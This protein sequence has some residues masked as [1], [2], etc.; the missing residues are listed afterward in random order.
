MK[1]RVISI[2]IAAVMLV[3]A[4]PM[5]GLLSGCRNTGGSGFPDP[6]PIVFTGG[7]YS[8]KSP[9]L[10][11]ELSSVKITADGVSSGVIP[12]D[13]AFIVETSG[14]TDVETLANYLTMT[15]AIATSVTRLSS[16]KFRIVPSSGKLVPG[17][18]YR[19]TLGDPENPAASYAFQTQNDMVVTSMFPGDKTLNVPVDT[20]IEVTFSEAVVSEP[21]MKYF[22]VSPEVKGE[23]SVYPNGRTVLFRP[24][25]KLEYNTVYTVTVNSGIKGISG[26]TLESGKTATFRTCTKAYESALGSD[27]REF[28]RILTTSNDGWDNI[29]SPRSDA[30]MRFTVYT[31][32]TETPNVTCDLYSFG[33]AKEAADTIIAFETRAGDDTG[34]GPDLSGLTKV[35][36]F[37]PQTEKDRYTTN[38]FLDLGTGLARG[39]YVAKITAS[40]S[41]GFGKT[42]KDTKSVIIQVSN[43]RPYTVSSNGK[44]IIWINSIANAEGPVEGAD[45]TVSLLSRNEGWNAE[46]VGK[47]QKVKTDASGIAEFDSSEAYSAVIIAEK[48]SDGIVV[49]AAVRPEDTYD[50]YLSYVYTDREVYFSDD[51]INFSGYITP[52]FG[53]TVPDHLYLETGLSTLKTRVE[54]DKNG[55][56]RGSFTYS[57][58]SQG[59]YQLKFSDES[60]R[61][62]TSGTFRITEE[63]KPQYTASISFDKLF[64]RRGE[65][66]T[67]TLTAS[68][69]DGTPAEGLEFYCMLS[70]FGDAHQTVRTDEKGEAKIVYKSRNLTDREVRGT[71]PVTLYFA[72]ELTNF[73][74]QYLYVQDS[75]PYFHSD[76]CVA[77]R[78]D[79]TNAVVTLNRRDTS[80]LKTP[81]NMLWRVFPENTVGEPLSAAN[82]LSYTL[83]KNVIVR[84]EKTRYDSYTKKNVKYYTC[85]VRKSKVASDVKSFVNGVA[86]FPLL[87]VSGF[88][89][90]YTYEVSFYDDTSN[91]TYTYTLNGTAGKTGTG[92]SGS[93]QSLTAEILFNDETYSVSDTVEAE[94]WTAPEKRKALF[95]IR[96]NGI[97]GVEYG[98]KVRFSFTDS[99]IAD[100]YLYAVVFDS[101][102]GEYLIPG[103]E[104][105][106]D[107]ANATLKPVITPS[108]DTYKPGD[109]AIVKIRVPGAGGGVAVVSIVDEACFALGDQEIEPL[110]IFSKQRSSAATFLMNARFKPAFTNSDVDYG[111]LSYSNG[112]KSSK[113]DNSLSLSE[114]RPGAAPESGELSDGGIGSSDWYIRKYFAD[115]PVYDVVELDSDGCGTLVFTVPD[116]ITSWRISTYALCGTGSENGKLKTGASVSDVICTLPFFVNVGICEQYIVGDTISLS[117]R[118]YGSEATG[119]VNYTAVLT[120]ALGNEKGRT[121]GSADSKERCWLKFELSE[122][123]QYHV[124]VYA[125][126]GENKDAATT[127]F[128]LVTSAVAADVGR[129]LAV[130]ELKTITPVYYPVKVVFANRT[131]SYAFYERI[132]SLLSNDRGSGRT[133]EYAGLYAAAAAR[134]ALYGIKAD[135]EQERLMRLM[136]DNFSASDGQFRVFPYSEP[137][138]ELTALILTLGLPFDTQTLNYI[139]SACSTSVNSTDQESPEKLISNVVSLAALGEPVLDTLYVIA[140]KAGNYSPEAKLLLALGF[141]VCGDYPAAHDVY[142]LVKSEIGV[143]DSEYGSLKFEAGDFDTT[144]QLSCLAL[145]S[146]ARID[147]EDAAKLALWLSENRT[148][149]VSDRIALAAYIKHFLPQEAADALEFTYTIGESSETVKIEPGCSF[150]LTLSKQELDSLKTSLPGDTKVGVYYR[151]TMEEAL[152]DGQKSDGRVSITKAMTNDSHGNCLV[153]LRISGRST[154]VNEYFELYDLIPSGARFLSI[155][156]SSSSRYE[157]GTVAAYA[158]IY[159]SSGQNMTG[160]VSLHNR[161][162]ENENNWFRQDCPEYGFEIS[163]SYVIRG[164]VEGTFTAESAYIR[165][166]RT[167]AFSLTDRIRVT[168]NEKDKWKFE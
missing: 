52:S 51:T 131:P 142:A 88:E 161:I 24:S 115:N 84:T 56:F 10:P 58:C 76:Y 33:S 90:Y 109:K 82:A 5:G 120:D 160:G 25:S 6:E 167:G 137:D 73:E 118:S 50:Y 128:T 126:C 77:T 155:D 116:N 57:R 7:D 94:I 113:G 22:T 139:A 110:S 141:A 12:V 36:T 164:A 32:I 134:E 135:Q 122:P 69:F 163:V 133:D 31:S 26:R 104:I 79:K 13:G 67:V 61:I 29:F 19:L 150:T 153:T 2:I 91:N 165:N 3:S 78:Q 43:F 44:S 95:V 156:S 46:I 20:G 125:E 112:S 87:E 42:L 83:W 80:G 60:G 81:E 102:T 151:G 143:E 70:Y 38:C 144:V 28:I 86:E 130:S 114:E 97:Y 63:Q 23:F 152:L 106:Y 136:K 127:D 9:A 146:A 99:M 138:P 162:Y 108:S 154:R 140:D 75:V 68:F 64:Y 39:V 123:G 27:S 101:S 149:S 11:P 53:G 147:R 158:Y 103:E 49:C 121:S 119:T 54:V 1:K 72:A 47:Q 48:G 18:I 59:Y 17:Q 89:G 168:I 40:V 37:T 124:T 14:E 107:T 85:E 129:S 16:N 30:V 159:N 45:V 111:D 41:Y 35:G 93:N 65:Q 34:S 105:R 71:N 157:S 148:N 166:P 8:G 74:T 117:A 100:G 132:T 98:S 145:M 92:Y 15:P 66:I 55:F 4:L 21:G 62:L 96:S